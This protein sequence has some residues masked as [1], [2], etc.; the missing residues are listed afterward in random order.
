MQ[1]LW[2]DV[3]DWEDW[4]EV[5]NFGRLRRKE[6]TS[7]KGYKA[8]SRYLTGVRRPDGAVNVTLTRPTYAKRSRLAG[9]GH[10]RADIQLHRIVLESFCGLAPEGMKACFLNGDRTNCRLTNLAWRHPSSI[11]KNAAQKGNLAKKMTEDS[12][13]RLRKM[14]DKGVN[15]DKI[16][17]K[18]G[19]NRRQVYKI[20]QRITW[21]WLKG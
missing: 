4:Y 21:S 1:E 17:Q 3:F 13:L 7:A 19:I 9:G 11:A 20:G 18:F 5:S 15:R 16:A 2:V 8:K 12:V 10:L 6:R 14:F